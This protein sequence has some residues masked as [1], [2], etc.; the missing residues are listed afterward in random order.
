MRAGGVPWI[1]PIAIEARP[2]ALER[3]LR[4]D[5]RQAAVDL[6]PPGNLKLLKLC[7][8]FKCTLALCAASSL[9]DDR[10]GTTT[11]LELDA[12]ARLEVEGLWT[13]RRQ[14]QCV[15]MRIMLKSAA[16]AA[17]DPLGEGGVEPTSG[18]PPAQAAAE[19]TETGAADTQLDQAQGIVLTSLKSSFAAMVAADAAATGAQGGALALA[20]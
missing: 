11:S 15:Y 17:D 7:A 19:Q 12:T 13:T 3:L 9:E 10:V 14:A 6:V 5:A 8:V 1:E 2:G 20:R 16:P 18:A 4:I